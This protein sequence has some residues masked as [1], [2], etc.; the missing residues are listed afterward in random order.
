VRTVDTNPGRHPAHA[1]DRAVR[2]PVCG[3]DVGA[4]FVRI[5]SVPVHCN[6]LWPTRESALEAPRGDIHLTFCDGCGHVFNLAFDPSDT[7][8]GEAYENSLHHSAVFQQYAASLV[9]DLVTRRD[10]RGRDIVEIGAGQGDFLQMLCSA[11][12]NR[13]TGFDPSA[14]EASNDGSVRLVAAPYDERFAGEP[15]DVIVCRQVLEHIARPDEFVAMVRRVI[16]DRNGT[17]VVFE[18]PNGE[19]SFQRGGIWDVIYEHCGYFTPT[20]LATVFAAQGFAVDRLDAMFGGQFLLVEA[21]VGTRSTPVADAAIGRIADDVQ[22]FGRE[23]AEVVGRWRAN[24]AELAFAGGTAVVWGAG[25]KGVSFLNAVD[26]AGAVRAAVDINPRKQGMHVPGTGQPIVGPEQLVS[27][28]PDFV[29]AMNPNYRHEIRDR[30][31]AL[32]LQSGVVDAT[33]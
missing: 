33:R 1:S 4:P 23:Y 20:S 12:H 9:E 2:C 30:I 8:Y 22:R 26:H 5:D 24:L 16:G 13:G 11:G 7:T 28:P 31:D 17:W 14:L 15:A 3:D 25:S 29:I 21:S 19:W 27:D 6:V 32:G 18:V 10:L